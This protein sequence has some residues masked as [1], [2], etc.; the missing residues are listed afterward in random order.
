MD[1]NSRSK[2]WIYDLLL[3]VVLLAAGYFRLTGINWDQNQH[4]HPDERFMTMVETGIAP[5][6]SLAEYFNT[7][8]SS[9]N[10]NNRGYTFYVYGDLPLII[11]RY[12]AEWVKMTDYDSVTLVGRALSAVADLGSI[13]LLYLIAMRLYKRKVALLATAFMAVSVMLIQQSHFFTVDSYANFFILLATLF[14][15]KVMLDKEK[16]WRDDWQGFLRSRL[17]WNTIAF[18]LA[19][20]MSVASKLNAAPLAILLPG[21]LFIRYFRESR[22]SDAQEPDELP[23]P[24]DAAEDSSGDSAESLSAED[25]TDLVAEPVLRPFKLTYKWAFILLILGAFISVLSFRIFQPY[26]FNG[27]G[28]FNVIPNHQ[29]VQNIMDERAQASG[30]VDFPPALQWARRS[31]LFSWDNMVAWGFGWPLGLLAWAGFLYMGWCMLKGEWKEHLLLWGWTGAYFVWQSLQWNPTM[32]YE[33]PIYPLLAMMGA[34]FVFEVG[35][36][37]FP[38]WWKRREAE[39]APPQAFSLKPLAWV[40]GI[41]VLVAAAAWAF[42]F[43]RIYTRDQTRVQASRWIY[44]NVPGPINLQIM[45]ADGS[46]YNQPLPVAPNF[47]ISS[48]SP[49]NAQFTPFVDGTLQTITLGKAYDPARS[50]NNQTLTIGL[51]TVPGAPANQLT[52]QASMVGTFPSD[53][54]HLQGTS[55]TVKL[56]HPVKVQKDATYYLQFN[57]TGPLILA[58]SI[59]VN[60]SSWDDGLPLRIDGYDAYGGIYQGDHNFE[61]YWD[62]NADKLARFESNL[63]QGDYL[64][65]SSNRQ[66][67]TTT[68]VPERYPLTTTY[69]RDLIGCP[70]DKDVIWCYNVATP[71]MFQ[72]KLGYDLVKVFESFPTL[73]PFQFNDQFAEEAFTVYD[74]PKVLIFKKDPNYDTQQV[75]TLLGAVDLSQVVHITPRQASS[76]PGNL[77]LPANA[78]AV[79]QAGGTWSQLFS[80]D[81]LQNKYPVVGLL[82]WYLALGLLGLFMYPILRQLLPGLPDRGYPLSRLAG[83]LVLSYF[84]WVV[85]SIGGAYTRT[86]IMAGYGLIVLVGVV[87]AWFNRGELMEELKSKGRFFLTVEGLFF[88]LFVIDLAIRLGNP[89]LWH[90]ARGGERPMD[91]SYLNAVLK[92]TTFPPFDPW[93]AG[94]YINYYYWGYVLVGTLIKMLGV[95]PSIAYNFVLPSLFAMLGIGGFCIAWNLVSAFHKRG[96]EGNEPFGGLPLIS[97]IAGAV[98]LVLVGNLGTVRMIYQA[99]QRMAVG[100]SLF[101]QT[102][103][104]IPERW[105]W[106]I[107]GIGKLF[108]GQ[109]LPIGQGDWYWNPSRVIPPGPGNEITEFPLFTFLYSDLHA[110]MI[111]MPVTVLAIG[112]VVSVLLARNLSRWS[113]LGT[114]AF[115]GLVIGSLYSINTWDYPTYLALAS[116]VTAYAI[117]RYAPVTERKAGLSPVIQRILLAVAGVL[118]LVVLSV[119]FFE[120]YRKWY[121]LGYNEIQ[122]WTD[123][124]TPIWSYLTHWGLFLFIIISWIVW[125]TRQWLAQT[126]V[127]SLNKLKPYE[128]IIELGL[129]V[130]VAV[131]LIFLFVLKVPITWLVLPLMVWALILIFRPGQPDSKRLV[132]FMIATGLAITLMVEV[133]AL[134]GDIGR[135][136][137]IFKFYVQVWI[138]F[139]ISS[140]AALGWLLSEF[141]EWTQGWRSVWQVGGTL[142]LLGALLFTFTA[143]M[144][145]IHDRMAPNVPFTFDSMTYMK[146]ATYFDNAQMDLSQDYNAIRWM[147]DNVQGSPVIVEANTVEYRWGTRFTV[148]TGLPGVVGWNWHQRQQRGTIV[149]ADWVTNRVQEIAD[150]YSTTDVN[151]AEAFLKKY[152]VKYIIVGQLEEA[153]YPPEDL[154]KFAANDGKLWKTVYHAKDT[155]IYQVLP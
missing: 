70:P 92:S 143:S 62:D 40:L 25:E 24:V 116:A 106:A 146:Y 94:G 27:P 31:K 93:Y 128:V 8:T 16:P 101:Q 53:S 76:Y 147:Q 138:L 15:V 58:G 121:G 73:G 55:Y 120:P 95:V 114:L 127:S 109:S 155:T 44:Q 3:V 65:I 54:A 111:A 22:Q 137:T 39:T 79:Q 20:G 50:G 144:D 131:A 9:L 36:W 51:S 12:V 102:N 104:L 86:L 34:W 110:H 60:E 29:W 26:A 46:T 113:W 14:A 118:L 48:T 4:L 63:D 75:H 82:L 145:K 72:G 74:H 13:I 112:F 45:Q 135:M 151:Q 142:L 21:A 49:Y 148:Y 38:K 64:F 152:N 140:A 141:S 136:N 150:F 96:E 71:G 68:R 2:R 99:L 5:V 77:M 154:A 132:L 42:A 108:A 37:K 129:A 81:W 87:F 11:V 133:V 47:V 105:W 41:G 107:E 19:L 84:A 28:F 117:F 124:R 122:Q 10:P 6:Q 126:P 52:A 7:A 32:R 35:K 30:N 69:Y 91:F 33:L 97:G 100:D 43:T 17:V 153:Y 1:D 78:E 23:A 85:A 59:P 18:G 115:G 89:D 67:A 57:A 125:E 123:S 66:W 90:P 130:L 103:I 139:A 88:L 56:N 98:G 83:L 80:Y 119:L 61:M 134:S 149:P